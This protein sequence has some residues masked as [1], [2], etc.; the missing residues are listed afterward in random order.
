MAKIKGIDFVLKMGQEILGGK[1]GASLSISSDTIDTT[2][3]DSQGWKEKDY[4]FK[5][6]S[7]STDGLLISNDTCYEAV[8]NALFNGTEL[9]VEI[10]RDGKKYTGKCLV[11]AL[12]SDAPFDDNM[13]YS[14]NLEGTGALAKG[15]ATQV[16][17]K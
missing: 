2:T 10:I 6:W 15:V 9:A 17:S 11:T 7:I 1:K 3:A 13:S 14:V 4:G 16:A 12:E 5:E 8:E